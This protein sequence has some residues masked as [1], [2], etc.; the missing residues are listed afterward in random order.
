MASRSFVH[1][2]LYLI[3]WLG[4]KRATPHDVITTYKP[5]LKKA[6]VFGNHDFT[7]EE[8]AQYIK[9][10]KMDGVFFGSKWIAHPDLAL[11]FEHGKPLG[12]NIDYVH[13]YGDGG[14]LEAQRKGYTDYPTLTSYD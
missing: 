10:G 5:I 12:N 14:D 7:G 4:K 3:L 1:C 9:E 11:R 13:L 2:S 6:L 8:A